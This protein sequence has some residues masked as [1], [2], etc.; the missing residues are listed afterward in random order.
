MNLRR[1]SKLLVE[2][3]PVATGDIAFNLIVFFLV[4]VAVSPDTGRRQ[5][6]P[7]AEPKKD[8]KEQ[9]KP[10]EVSLARGVVLLN[11]NAVALKDFDKRLEEAIKLKEGSG[12]AI[13]EMADV[14]R[15]VV[16]STKDDKNT[17]YKQWIAVTDAIERIGGIVTLQLEEERTVQTE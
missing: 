14:N 11:G 15:I 16:V 5:D 3:P 13:R 6:I 2:S 8:E 1:R 9:T 17:P 4:C 7:R 10:T 12:R